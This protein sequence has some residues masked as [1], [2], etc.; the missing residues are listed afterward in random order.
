MRTTIKQIILA[1]A[2]F[3]TSNFIFAQAHLGVTGITGWHNTA[4]CSVPYT[5]MYINVKNYD[6]VTFNGAVTINIIDGSGQHFLDSMTVMIPSGG[7]DSLPLPPYYFNQPQ[8]AAGHDV[9]IV[10]PIANNVA[11]VD[12]FTDSVFV[13]CTASIPVFDAKNAFHVFPNPA[14]EYLLYESEYPANTIEYVRIID[15]IK[16]EI[17]RHEEKGYSIPLSNIP[18]GIYV[19][20]L[21]LKDGTS[22]KKKFVR[23]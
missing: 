20:E 15:V 16:G 9:V 3:L 18:A 8:Y 13:I 23:E 11:L 5:N 6:S 14:N 17:Y 1:A 12:S 4:H 22:I 19:I 10:W 21:K 7:T 2:L